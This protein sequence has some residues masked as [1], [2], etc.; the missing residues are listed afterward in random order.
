MY[1]SVKHSETLLCFTVVNYFCCS[2]ILNQW[3]HQQ[4][5]Y[6]ATIKTILSGHLMTK[7]SNYNNPFK[8]K[9]GLTRSLEHSSC[10][11]NNMCMRHKDEK[12]QD[13][14]LMCLYCHLMGDVYFPLSLQ[15]RFSSFL[16]GTI[17]TLFLVLEAHQ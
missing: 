12:G 6:F 11:K 4:K 16:Q 1:K 5:S 7:A 15:L 8:G 3:E 9:H 14:M 17:N 13:R 10:S 2:K